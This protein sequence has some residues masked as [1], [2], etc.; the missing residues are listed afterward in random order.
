MKLKYY[1]LKRLVILFKLLLLWLTMDGQIYTWGDLNQVNCNHSV[2]SI[3]EG[4]TNDII[5]LGKVA[6]KNFRNLKIGYSRITS[7][8][9]VKIDKTFSE[10]VNL[11]D[12]KSILYQPDGLLR[13]YGTSISENGKMAPYLNFINPVNNTILNNIVPISNSGCFGDVKTVS[14]SEIM[15]L[16]GFKV[17]S[18]DILNI[19]VNRVNI[20][21]TD[22][23]KKNV[24][25]DS[26]FNE[27]P[28][29]LYVL[30]DTSFLILGRRDIDQNRSNSYG[31]IYYISPDFKIKWNMQVL[32]STGLSNQN[33]TCGKEGWIYYFCSMK[34]SYGK[35]ASKGFIFDKEGNKIRQIEIDSLYINSILTLQNGSI[36][37]AGYK[38]QSKGSNASEKACYIIYDRTLKKI[39]SRSLGLQDK[40]DA[41]FITIHNSFLPTTSEFSTVYQMTNGKIVLGGRVWMPESIAP[42]KILNSPRVNKYLLVI[43]TPDGDF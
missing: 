16:N 14:N 29:T 6:D 7:D 32:N 27:E 37:V 17:G 38:I 20:V 13:V 35:C 42:D 1:L 12:L 36:L 8:G 33:L 9:N 34:D 21:S 25:I 31:I 26:K 39:K 30:P 19:Y 15:L 22:I 24:V 41:D 3:V 28:K 43:L 23:E 40:P 18:A 5:I 11:Y 10:K 2:V 4:K